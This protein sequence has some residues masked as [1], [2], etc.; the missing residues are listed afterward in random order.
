VFN[1][2]T[3]IKPILVMVVPFARAMCTFFQSMVVKEDI[4]FNVSCIEKIQMP[5]N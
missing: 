4:V 1:I 2:W 5:L 3:Q